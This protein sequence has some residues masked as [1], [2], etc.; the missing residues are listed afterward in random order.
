VVAAHVFVGGLVAGDLH[1][2]HGAEHRNPDQLEDDPDIEH[3][4]ESVPG[5]DVTQCLIDNVALGTCNGWQTL[6]I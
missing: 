3:E 6:D 2:L 1:E 5:Y 4:G